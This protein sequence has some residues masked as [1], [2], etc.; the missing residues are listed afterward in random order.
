MPE[1]KA[2]QVNLETLAGG[3]AGELFDLE[4]ERILKNIQDPNTD[5]TAKR[6]ITL[7]VTIQADEIRESAVAMVNVVAK[8]APVRPHKSAMYLGEREGRMV[9]VTFDPRQG[10]LFEPDADPAV[11]P[12]NRKSENAS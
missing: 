5:P 8:L 10:S 3:A 4:F 9:A 12:I 1:A 7:T 2:M 11:S 6:Q